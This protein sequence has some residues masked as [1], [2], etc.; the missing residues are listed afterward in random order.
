MNII[1][2]IIILF[3]IEM[4]PTFFNRYC[5]RR[6]RRLRCSPSKLSDVRI[7]VL[8]AERAWAQAMTLRLRSK[9]GNDANTV[10]LHHRGRRCSRWSRRRLAKATSYAH[11]LKISC[12]SMG[13]E[14]VIREVEAYAN[15]LEA[16]ALESRGEYKKAA[17]LFDRTRGAYLAINR[18]ADT[19]QN[20]NIFMEYAAYCL[21][22][23]Q[24]CDI[25]NSGQQTSN[26][27]RDSFAAVSAQT[28]RRDP[29]DVKI[30][31]WCGRDVQVPTGGARQLLF[32]CR[33]DQEPTAADILNTRTAE[34]GVL[35]LGC[36]EDQAKFNLP[37]VA[38][39]IN[40]VERLQQL[41]E[42]VN[43]LR[44]DGA[45]TGA[46]GGSGG[47]I[48]ILASFELIQA[49]A[50]FVKERIKSWRRCML[51]SVFTSIFLDQSLMPDDI[52][53]LLD[54]LI[55]VTNDMTGLAGVRDANDETIAEALNARA[56]AL[57][58]YKSYFLGETYGASETRASKALSLFRQAIYLADRALQ[59]V[60]A[61]E[62]KHMNPVMLNLADASRASES[63]LRAVHFFKSHNAVLSSTTQQ[64][65]GES[66]CLE[67]GPPPL[68]HAWHEITP[69]KPVL[70]NLCH[71]SLTLP[72]FETE[73]AKTN[74]G[75]FGW[76]RR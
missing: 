18:P 44:I 42:L 5:G 76:F 71:T 69:S 53:H 9:T 23:T 54:N 14:N 38:N 67:F 55:Q 8:L 61:C 24:R 20:G 17:V 11:G 13:D 49:R 60:E 16:Q 41:E 73:I 36:P 57:L 45:L 58:A 43:Q 70:F 65:P 29:A 40:Y 21:A 10:P 26:M 1:A 48:G 75:L 30:L 72:L 62:M 64:S 46:R 2:G 51:D 32:A 68:L 4:H 27:Q 25:A 33:L 74:H 22:A 56:V 12:V 66:C 35:C 7:R 39:E 28:E 19:L 47:L 52:V 63:R 31:R 15:W 59:E 3:P 50:I 6:I 34:I 37:P